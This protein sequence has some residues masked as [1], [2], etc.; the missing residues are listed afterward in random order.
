MMEEVHEPEIVFFLL[1]LSN[2]KEIHNTLRGEGRHVND[3][4]IRSHDL[5]MR[6]VVNKFSLVSVSRLRVELPPTDGVATS[7]Q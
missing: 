2:C 4:Q 5:Q 3:G 7:N 6:L 1:L